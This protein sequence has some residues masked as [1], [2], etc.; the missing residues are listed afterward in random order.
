MRIAG[1]HT[2]TSPVQVW[3][4]CSWALMPLQD[5][6][7]LQHT[8]QISPYPPPPPLFRLSGFI[9]AVQGIVLD[10]QSAV[11]LHIP[12]CHMQAAS[13]KEEKTCCFHQIPCTRENTLRGF[14]SILLKCSTISRVF[15]SDDVFFQAAVLQ[16]V[17][18]Q[19]LFSLSLPSV[20]I[21]TSVFHL[22]PQHVCFDMHA[23]FTLLVDVGN[24][25]WLQT[26]SWSW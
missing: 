8:Y 2:R 1:I 21:S 9:S 3:T 24:I 15:A 23:V 13:A 26:R 25:E 11:G 5:G 12:E 20:G 16:C 14:L 7:N 18:K 4:H 22:P 19:I 17:G 10:L 6:V